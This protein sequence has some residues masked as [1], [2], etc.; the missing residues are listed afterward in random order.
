MPVV[1][2]SVLLAIGCI[3]FSFKVPFAFGLNILVI[4]EEVFGLK[5]SVD[6]EG[7]SSLAVL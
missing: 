5:F 7:K 2:K 4:Y 3:G 6:G 1:V